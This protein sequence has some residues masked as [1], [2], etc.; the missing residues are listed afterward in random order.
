MT[1]VE[2]Q[3]RQFSNYVP[4]TLEDF[5]GAPIGAEVFVRYIMLEPTSFI[6][7]LFDMF[8]LTAYGWMAE[9]NA[10]LISDKL[11]DYAIAGRVHVFSGFMIEQRELVLPDPLLAIYQ[12]SNE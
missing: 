6:D 3:R 12:L 5:R 7:T 9:P 8:M 10:V 4:I 2:W 11:E 1:L